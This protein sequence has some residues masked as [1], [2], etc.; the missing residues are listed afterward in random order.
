MPADLIEMNGE[1]AASAT[2]TQHRSRTTST[3]S[4]VALC[5]PLSA[6]SKVLRPAGRVCAGFLH[7][8]P[9]KQSQSHSR[10]SHQARSA[11]HDRRYAGQSMR[12]QT[13]SEELIIRLDSVSR[14]AKSL[15]VA[16]GKLKL[17]PL[18]DPGT[19]GQSYQ[20]LNL[21]FFR[22]NLNEHQNIRSRRGAGSHSKTYL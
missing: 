1:R 8:R 10:L 14:G 6:L 11:V 7:A 20:A 17:G 12:G 5:E 9:V 21:H 15:Q 16:A 13:L 22:I 19:P 2:V 18:H 3:S 4:S